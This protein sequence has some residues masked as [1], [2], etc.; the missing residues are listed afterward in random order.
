[1]NKIIMKSLILIDGS[2][3]L[4]RAYHAFPNLVNSIGESTG[5]IYGVLNMIRSLLMKYQFNYIGIVF[6]DKGKTFRNKLFTEYK[7]NRLPMPN[8]LNVQ[9]IPLFNILKALG[10]PVLVVPEVEADDVIGTLAFQAELYG[11]KVLIS[12]IDKDMIQ[13]VTSNITLINTMNKIIMGPEEVQNKY[14]FVPKLMIDFL[15]LVGD[16]SDNIPGVPGIGIKTA[17]ILLQN[18]G[19]LD[20]LYKMLDKI[21]I[22]NFRN[23]KTIV[24]KLK[25]HKDKAYLSYKLAKIKTNVK[26][27]Y[28]FTDLNLS[29]LNIDKLEKL[30]KKYEF[31]SWLLHLKNIYWLKNKKKNKCKITDIIK[32]N[33]LITE[34]LNFITE[35]ILQKNNYIT[36]LSKNILHQWIIKLKKAKI[37]SFMIDT[38]NIDILRAKIISLSFSILPNHTAFIP[39]ENIFLNSLQC[40]DYIYVLKKIKPLLEDKNILKVGQN[41]KFYIGILKNYNINLNGMIYDIILESYILGN[42]NGRCDIINLA[43]YY[44]HYK[45]LSFEEIFSVKKDKLFFHNISLLKYTFYLSKYVDITLKLHLVM[46]PKI[47]KNLILLKIFNK[48]DI[49]LIKVLSNIERNGVCIDSIMLLTYSTELTNKLKDLENQAHKLAG[50]FFN[51][52]STKQIQNILYEKKKLPILKKTPTGIPSTNEEVLYKLSKNYLLPKI[53]LRYRSL[54]KLKTT[55]ANKLPLMINSISGRIHT[56][57][58]QTV[59]ITGR[60]SSSNPNLQNI[61]IRNDEGRRIRKAFIAPK[62]YFIMSADYSQIELRIIAHLSQD[63]TLIQSF[64]NNQDIHCITASEIFCIPLHD[65]DLKQRYIAKVIN[66]GLIY[67]MSAFGLSCQLNISCSE[68]QRYI[69][70]YFEH[71]PGILKYI[72]KIRKEALNKGY[73]TTLDGRRL[74][75]PD[76]DSNNYIKRKAAERSAINA[77]MQGTASDIIKRA[78]ININSWIQKQSYSSLIHMIMQVHD[79]LVFEVHKSIIKVSN[80]HIRELMENSTKFTVPLKVNIGIGMNWNETH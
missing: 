36:I 78:M 19:G 12:T 1:M 2:S 46:W 79:E 29:I 15:A 56:S 39:L 16:I 3:Y 77:P 17:K 23:S 22:F 67:G 11:Y 42:M 60:L 25:E 80:T 73:V 64:F 33:N 75:L 6:D 38:D 68:A 18:F 30:F 57:Y 8:N 43:N 49:P 52:S 32:I 5:A 72:K 41:I 21:S 45:L 35:D 13:L 10:L 76:I 44:L 63:K 61:P 65:V 54:L 53:I 66:F 37:F 7:T 47:K 58:H 70:C 20:I 74:Y 4:Y 48:I 26:L 69:D 51:L 9:I 50:E 34:K 24:S 14:G 62:D 40:L 59:T 71:Y 31:K 55:Y 27:C 28:S